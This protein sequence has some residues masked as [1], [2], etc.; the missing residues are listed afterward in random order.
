MVCVNLTFLRR[1]LSNKAAPRLQAIWELESSPEAS[2]LLNPGSGFWLL[3][4]EGSSREPCPSLHCSAGPSGPGPTTGWPTKDKP[5]GSRVHHAWFLQRRRHRYEDSG[6]TVWRFPRQLQIWNNYVCRMLNTTPC[7]LGDLQ[8]LLLF[9]VK[10]LF[11]GVLNHFPE[12]VN[13]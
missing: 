4:E 1:A 2:A 8:T 6:S 10:G 3:K 9:V 5:Q 11:E 7:W 13:I 12:M